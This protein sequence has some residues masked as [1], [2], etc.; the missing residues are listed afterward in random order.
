MVRVDS[1]FYSTLEVLFRNKISGL[2]LTDE[3]GKITGNFSASDLRVCTATW[4]S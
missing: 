4:L 3:N 1:E 2:A